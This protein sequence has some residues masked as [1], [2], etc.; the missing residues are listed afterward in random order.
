MS[1]SSWSAFFAMGG[2][3]PFVWPAYGITVVVLTAVMLA[4]VLRYRKL[5]RALARRERRAARTAEK[6]NP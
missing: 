5:R 3:A 1:F 6:N 4:P 2:Y